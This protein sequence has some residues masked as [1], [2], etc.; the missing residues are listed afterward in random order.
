VGL[1]IWTRG[2]I[3]GNACPPSKAALWDH[4]RQ[5]PQEKPNRVLPLRLSPTLQKA[6]VGSQQ[7]YWHGSWEFL[8]LTD[9]ILSRLHRLGRHQVD[10]LWRML[11]L[12][13]D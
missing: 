12:G 6:K 1:K 10:N 7:H 3:A 8:G 4:Y 5:H 9:F 11:D 2:F 13:F